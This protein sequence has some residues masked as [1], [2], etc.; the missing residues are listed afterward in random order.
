ME[1]DAP[2]ETSGGKEVSHHLYHASL[3][4][5]AA[6]IQSEPVEVLIVHLG[7]GIGVVRHGTLKLLSH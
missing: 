1:G 6:R 2:E 4:G 3:V 5:P 7:E